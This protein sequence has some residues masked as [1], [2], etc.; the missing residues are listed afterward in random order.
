MKHLFFPIIILLLAYH[1]SAQK[2][3]SKGE[4]I[5]PENSISMDAFI[6]NVSTTEDSFKIEGIVDKVCQMKGCWMTLKNDEGKSVRIVFKDYGFFMPKDIS[7]QKVILE[8]SAYKEILD[9]DLA[10]HYAE[11]AN[12]E[13]DPTTKEQITFIASGVLIKSR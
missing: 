1:V 7:G 12:K 5:N 3:I 9:E 2:Y 13:Y 4:S 8:G 11:D 6:S 10:K